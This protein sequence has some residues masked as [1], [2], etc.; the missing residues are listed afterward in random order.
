[1][2]LDYLFSSLS[3][4][5][6]TKLIYEYGNYGHLISILLNMCVANVNFKYDESSTMDTL[7]I[8][9]FETLTQLVTSRIILDVDGEFAAQM[10][11]VR[12]LCVLIT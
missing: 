2:L 11:S 4:C 1:M 10:E 8:E 12:S 7:Y 9:V 6:I 3:V 5:S